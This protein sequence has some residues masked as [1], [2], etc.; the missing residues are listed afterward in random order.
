MVGWSSDLNEVKLFASLGL[1]SVAQLW[2]GVLLGSW[3][4][5]ILESG[6]RFGLEET[7][8]HSHV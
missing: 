8:K 3:I 6:T 5:G 7:A 4:L 2:G 1:A